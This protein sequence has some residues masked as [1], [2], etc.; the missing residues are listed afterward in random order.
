MAGE[1]WCLD[2]ARWNAQVTVST[3][4]LGVEVHPWGRDEVRAS[5]VLVS[6]ELDFGETGKSLEVLECYQA[7]VSAD[8]L[9]VKPKRRPLLLCWE[10]AAD[11]TKEKSK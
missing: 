3:D 4:T 8:R 11:P 2:R 7:E 9:Y 1:W 5:T 10:G 6:V